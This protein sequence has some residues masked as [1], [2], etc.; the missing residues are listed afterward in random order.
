[1]PSTSQLLG[2][3]RSL[4]SLGFRPHRSDLSTVFPVR[5]GVL[6]SS[7]KMSVIG[8]GVVLNPELFLTKYV[9]TD[10]ISKQG[11]ILRSDGPPR[12]LRLIESCLGV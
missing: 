3:A 11:P 5:L 9:C 1:M 4:L 2:A 10:P 7:N 8:F 6:S 12:H